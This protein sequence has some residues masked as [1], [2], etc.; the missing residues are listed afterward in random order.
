VILKSKYVK[1]NVIQILKCKCNK[2]CKKKSANI[3]MLV[4]TLHVIYRDYI[5]NVGTFTYS[6]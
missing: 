6:S 3:I 2:F 1:K 5:S 4:W